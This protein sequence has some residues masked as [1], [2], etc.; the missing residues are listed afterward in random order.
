MYY[1][2]RRNRFHTCNYLPII[3]NKILVF[4]INKNIIKNLKK[5][6]IINKCK[7]K[8]YQ[9]N[10]VINNYNKKSSFIFLM[11]FYNHQCI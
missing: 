11:I 8:I 5:N 9:K 3:K 1:H 2:W 7:F 6:L 10:L 4:E